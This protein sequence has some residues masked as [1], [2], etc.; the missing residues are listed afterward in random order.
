MDTNQEIQTVVFDIGN[1]L[2]EWQPERWFDQTIGPERRAALFAAVD[3][4]GMNDRVDRGSPMHDEVEAMARRHPDLADDIM[5]WRDNWIKMARPEI[6]H[7]VGLLRA[8]RAKGVP[9]AALSNFGR[10][11]FEIARASYPFLDEFDLLVISGDHGVI[12]PEPE[13]YA[14][15]EQACGHEPGALLFTDDRA[16]NIAAAQARGWQTHLFE[17]PKGLARRLVNAGL[18]TEAEA[19]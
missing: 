17:G 19:A 1:V 12:K 4:H 2:I 16:D 5:L 18:L 6:P 3:L 14:L 13:I 7:S 9:V 10:E 11:T 15:I 8:L